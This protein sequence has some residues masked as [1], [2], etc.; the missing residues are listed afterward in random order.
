MNLDSKP[1]PNYIHHL[2]LEN[3][4]CFGKAD[5][6]FSKGI[7]VFIGENGT[8]K[9]HVLKLLCSLEDLSPIFSENNGKPMYNPMGLQLFLPEMFKVYEAAN[10]IRRNRSS[11]NIALVEA[12]VNK[13]RIIFQINP[14]NILLE[15]STSIS[16]NS[17]LILPK[18]SCVYIPPQQMLSAFDGFTAAYE[19]RES[20]IDF[21]YYLLAKKLSLLPLKGEKLKQAEELLQTLREKIA[22]DV[23][24]KHGKFFIRHK[25]F[26]LEATLEADGVNKIAQLIYL[27][28]NGS[29]NRN[30]ILFW[31]EPENS[32]N[33]RWIRLIADFLQVLALEGVQIFVATHDYLLSHHLSLMAEYRTELNEEAGKVIV[34]EMRFFSFGK[35]ESGTKV[36]A[37]DELSMVSKNAILDEHANHDMLDEKMLSKFFKA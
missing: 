21:T 8:G 26:D 12:D 15:D 20:S 30:T 11:D 33:P 23:Y 14:K 6:E 31:D 10:L 5:I 24:Q 22:I 35:G 2:Q 3:F 18:K 4:T 16:S 7:N 1:I 9:T 37:G 28:L 29:L 17:H 19:S 36:S 34:P 27:I 13:K 32:L 25:D